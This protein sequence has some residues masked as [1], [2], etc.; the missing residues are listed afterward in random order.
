MQ[1]HYLLQSVRNKQIHIAIRQGQVAL[2]LLGNQS[3]TFLSNIYT[4]QIH[5]YCSQGTVLPSLLIIIWQLFLSLLAIYFFIFTWLT[6]LTHS[7]NLWDD[8]MFLLSFP[9]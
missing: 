9:L 5:I 8:I 6:S 1:S 2:T 3:Y 7:S 4:A